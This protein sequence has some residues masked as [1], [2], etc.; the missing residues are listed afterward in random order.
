M[1]EKKMT[2]LTLDTNI[3]IVGLGV[4]GGGYA[5]ALSRKGY[6]VRCITKEQKD[7]DYALERGMIA[8]GTTEVD[9]ALVGAADLIVFALYPHIFVDWIKQYQH[10][11]KPGALITDV[12]GVKGGVVSTVQGMLRDDVEFVAAHPMAG[13]ERS[14]VEYSDDRVFQGANF[15]ITP[16]EK[17]TPEAIAL[18]RELGEVLG[19]ARITE[20]TAEE[21]DEMI[22]FL[23]Q[24]THCIAVT[25]MTCNNTPSLEEYTGD[26]FR[27][28][29]RIAK[30]ND[31]MWSEL[32]LLNRDALLKQM[33]CFC[34]EFARLR[35][36][37]VTGDRESMR[38]MMRAS[39]ARRALFDKQQPKANMKK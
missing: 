17:N 19:F 2:Q 18:C 21:H 38:D 30:I 9:P 20:L 31:E 14:G 33:D 8:S 3:L 6:Q 39:T 25:L 24:L 11:F 29:T 1:N 16:T 35:E 5:S 13:R 37:L 4:I 27:D 23:S 22:A 12:T 26:S 32:F 36:M 10:L 7:I 28:L 34:A 15:I